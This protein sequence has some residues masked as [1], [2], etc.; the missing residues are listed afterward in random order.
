VVT[1]RRD[2]HTASI[3]WT[4]AALKQELVT[5]ITTLTNARTLDLE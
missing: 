4:L 2:S 1:R 3:G 5:S